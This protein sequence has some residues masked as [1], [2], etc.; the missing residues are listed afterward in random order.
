MTQRPK[1]VSKPTTA[2]SIF[3]QDFLENI[4]DWPIDGYCDPDGRLTTISDADDLVTEVMAPNAE[5]V[6]RSMVFW[7]RVGSTKIASIQLPS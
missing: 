3:D 2:S 1:S 7:S 6:R 5:S 4:A